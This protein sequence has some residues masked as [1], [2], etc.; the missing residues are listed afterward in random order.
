MTAFS[1]VTG[2]VTLL[3]L[4]ASGGKIFFDLD[5]NGKY[6]WGAEWIHAPAD[7]DTNSCICVKGV[8]EDNKQMDAVCF[9]GIGRDP[10]LL[11]RLMGEDSRYLW[12]YVVKEIPFDGNYAIEITTDGHDGL[13]FD[14]VYFATNAGV[15]MYG[16]DNTHG[17]C[18]SKDKDDTFDKWSTFDGSCQPKIQFGTW[19]PSVTKLTVDGRMLRGYDIIDTTA[20]CE[21]VK[22]EGRRRRAEGSADVDVAVP[23]S[24]GIVEFD[25][26]GSTIYRDPTGENPAPVLSEIDA[27]VVG[28][29]HQKIRELV[30]GNTDV[31]DG[32]ID[33]VLNSAM[34]DV[35][36][37]VERQEHDGEVLE[38]EA[39][40]IGSE[41]TG[42]NIRNVQERLQNLE[43]SE[44]SQEPLGDD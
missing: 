12:G 22:A 25:D 31:T 8:R 26:I 29:L 28:T 36:H 13:W 14:R 39:L 38:P 41:G 19:T 3:A 6:W 10:R 7:G 17:W 35:E 27:L 40:E 15:R 4:S 30:Q 23:A 21:A 1:K 20:K 11:A 18:L 33:S 9:D 24:G 34:L 32:Q 42:S 5:S 44:G 2:I 16:V 37:I 43:E